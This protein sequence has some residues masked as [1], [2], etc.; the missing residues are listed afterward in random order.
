MAFN[1]KVAIDLL[2]GPVAA[3]DAVFADNAKQLTSRNE[4]SF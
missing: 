1:A 4:I 2:A 3:D